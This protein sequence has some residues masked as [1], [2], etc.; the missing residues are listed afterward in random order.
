MTINDLIIELKKLDGDALVLVDDCESG[1]DGSYND[2]KDIK[3]IILS[4]H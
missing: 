4:R 2:G 3:A 1:Y